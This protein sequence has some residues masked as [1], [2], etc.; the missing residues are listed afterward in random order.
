MS[1]AD[2]L[3][4]IFLANFSFY[5]PTLATVRN[6]K[7]EPNPTTADAGLLTVIINNATKDDVQFFP[8]F[9]PKTGSKCLVIALDNRSDRSVAIGF[10]QID[11]LKGKIGGT[12]EYELSASG[13][14]IK[15]TP[16][17]VKI[18][19]TG[20]TIGTG[21]ITAPNTTLLKTHLTQL[22]TSLQSLYTAIKAG[23]ITSM[24]GGAS[25]KS[26]LV[27]ATETI[28]LPT[29]PTGLDQTNLKYSVGV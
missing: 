3:V 19:P 25:F 16:L 4:T 8:P 5:W 7:K 14:E 17:E 20:V 22:N 26:A 29:V 10:N 23:T 2:D 27:L 28:P 15:L 18:N 24:D 6:V 13:L 9:I 11:K 12:L 1:I 21:S